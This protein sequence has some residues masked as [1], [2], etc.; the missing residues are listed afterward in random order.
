MRPRP[1]DTASSANRLSRPLR[2]HKW[3][4]PTGRPPK[5]ERPYP[6]PPKRRRPPHSHLVT[7]PARFADLGK[8]GCPRPCAPAPADANDRPPPDL[9]PEEPPTNPVS[10]ATLSYPQNPRP[11]HSFHRRWPA[12]RTLP[13][14]LRDRPT[15]GSLTPGHRRWNQAHR[16][17]KQPPGRDTQRP[18]PAQRGYNNQ[19]AC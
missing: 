14:R 1:P 19:P 4:I 3:V 18:P 6:P 17:G 12:S 10:Y 5:T 11:A 2:P 8:S 9:P 13:R 16:T 15:A 7:E